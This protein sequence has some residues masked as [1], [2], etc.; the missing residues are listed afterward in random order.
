MNPEK[1]NQA[2]ERVNAAV[3]AMRTAGDDA[4][5][6]ALESEFRAAHAEAEAAK[7]NLE[8][9]EELESVSKRFTPRAVESPADLGMDDSEI[10]EYS[11]VRAINAA[12]TG[13]WK[14]AELEREASD[15]IAKRVGRDANGFFMPF[16]VQ[17]QKR[18]LVVGTTTAGG[19]LVETDLKSGSFIDMLRNRMA[20]VQAGATFLSG[21]EGNVA[22]PRQTGGATGYWVA[23]S[24][25]VTE[26]Q[27]AVDQVTLAP[28]THGAFTD[29]SRKLLK[30]SSID[31]EN[32]VRSDLAT[33]CALGI[34]LAA[35][36]GTG[37]DNQP[38]GI[39]ATSGI[40]SVAG[41]DNG[42]APTW[43]HMVALETEI[44]QDNADVGN[45]AYITN[46]KV[47]GKLKGT[48]KVAST[49]SQMI[50]QDGEYPINGYKCYISNQVSSTLT[51]G[52]QSLSSAIFFGNWADLLIGQWGVLDMLVDPYTGGTAGTVRVVAL[53][54]VDVAV[55]HAQSF[56]A[57]LDA[58]TA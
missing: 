30:Q 14:G 38:T 31:V 53:Q 37:Q 18:D 25:S 46:A 3:E 57:M 32:F 36:H 44:A 42:L 11:I 54:D 5:L 24:T 58:L 33:V 13:N 19:H 40:G 55:R 28:K 8:R 29:I 47:R 27:Q 52:N 39:A 1:Y 20:V 51:K 41:G 9:G 15:E 12:A 21:L 56:A 4:D 26:S 49:D 43:A 10:R 23:E 35:L 17:R 7:A 6:S 45:L 50:W 2:C 22:I 34:D 16:D 48:A